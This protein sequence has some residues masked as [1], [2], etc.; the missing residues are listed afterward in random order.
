[1]KN[2]LEGILEGYL[3]IILAVLVFGFVVA[4]YVGEINYDIDANRRAYWKGNRDM[5]A[6]RFDQ[7][8]RQTGTI[9]IQEWTPT[10]LSYTFE[11]TK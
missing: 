1:M 10:S 8:R 9:I 5:F 7:M 4:C 3:G 2:W 11:K 6:T